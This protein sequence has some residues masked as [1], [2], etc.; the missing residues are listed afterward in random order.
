MSLSS[1][2]IS[3]NDVFVSLYDIY[4][5]CPFTG[6]QNGSGN[7]AVNARQQAYRQG[8]AVTDA[9]AA[10]A[11]TPAHL[12]VRAENVL[13]ELAVELTGEIPPKGRWAPPSKL[14]GKLTF[15]H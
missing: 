6:H 3:L 7:A 8:T 9:S 11:A 1:K 13:K 14:L 15:R 2:N 5:R 10:A 4:Q 12:S